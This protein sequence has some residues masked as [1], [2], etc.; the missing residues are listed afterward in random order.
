MRPKILCGALVATALAIV[1]IAA[2]VLTT[3]PTSDPRPLPAAAASRTTTTPAPPARPAPPALP[4]GNYAV[5]MVTVD[6]AKRVVTV[7]PFSYYD[8][9]EFADLAYHREEPGTEPWPYDGYSENEDTTTLR[10]PV[11]AGVP[12]TVV[13]VGYD[14]V[15]RR[16]VDVAALAKVPP[17]AMFWAT[18]E[19]GRV[20]ALDQQ[21]RS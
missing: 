1:A 17:G 8:E 18:V 12:I 16:S 10:L 20:T 5:E 13:Q 19:G 7:D 21:F 2:A 11:A 15:P 3:I 14:T 6:V 4:E 9:G